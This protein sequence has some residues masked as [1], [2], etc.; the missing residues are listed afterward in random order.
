MLRKRF[1]KLRVY[2][3]RSR[4]PAEQLAALLTA[5]KQG[6]RRE[7]VRKRMRRKWR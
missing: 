5:Q 1:G 3:L 2:E 7:G 6:A 4:V